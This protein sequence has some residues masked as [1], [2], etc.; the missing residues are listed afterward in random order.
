MSA[1]FEHT[2]AMPSGRSSACAGAVDLGQA[3]R[4]DF[5]L[6]IAAAADLLA[7]GTGLVEEDPR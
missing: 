3:E 1:L 4:A 5:A 2:M 6:G 7:V